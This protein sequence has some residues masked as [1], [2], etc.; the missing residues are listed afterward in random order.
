MNDIDALFVNN[1]AWARRMR[2]RDPRFF[3]R[4]AHQQAPRHLWI[5]CSDSRVPANQIIGLDPGEVFVH[6][7]VANLV[8][9]TD[10]NCLSVIQFAIDVLRIEHVMVVGHYGC[11]GVLAALQRRRLGLVDNWLQHVRDVHL[12]HATRLDALEGEQAQ[13]DRLCELNVIEQVANLSRLSVV[14]DAWQ[15]GQRLSVHGLIYG[16]HDGLLR[17]LNATMSAPTELGTWRSRVLRTL[18]KRPRGR[19]PAQAGGTAVDERRRAHL[20]EVPEACLADP[21]PHDGRASDA[22]PGDTPRAQ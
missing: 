8:V 16:V 21:L 22:I 6:R 10:L 1:R 19:L 5:G 11:G 18:W 17:N 9:H 4:L 15:R 12:A 3:E 2:E 20:I 13:H 14:A 7:N